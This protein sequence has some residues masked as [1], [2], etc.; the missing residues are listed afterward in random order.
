M[1]D[2]TQLPIPDDVD[3]LKRELI[4]ADR[5]RLAWQRL[6]AQSLFLLSGPNRT[7]ALTSQFLNNWHDDDWT[8][9]RFEHPDGAGV[10]QYALRARD[11]PKGETVCP[12]CRGR[13]VIGDGN[14]GTKPCPKCAR[15]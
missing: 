3:E 14:L 10:V 9:K 1:T 7:L 6:F 4:R 12:I 15:S 5:E 8:L 2:E 11:R 13:A